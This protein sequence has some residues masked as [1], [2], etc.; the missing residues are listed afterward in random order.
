MLDWW[1]A[2]FEGRNGQLPFAIV[3]LLEWMRVEFPI[4]EIA[5]KKDGL[6]ARC[7]L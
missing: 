5:T 3:K 6:G 2:I 4:V 1:T 7:P